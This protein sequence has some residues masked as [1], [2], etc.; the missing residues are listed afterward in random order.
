M[1]R[2]IFTLLGPYAMEASSLLLTFLETQLCISLF[3][4]NLKRRRFFLLRI[5]FC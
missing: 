4:R 5:L 3:A 2:K 1:M